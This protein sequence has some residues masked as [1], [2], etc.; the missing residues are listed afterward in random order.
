MKGATP[1]GPKVVLARSAD[2]NRKLSVRLRLLGMRP[3]PVDTVE[4]LEPSDWSEVDRALL[5]LARFDWVVLTSARGAEAFVDRARRLGIDHAKR[6]PRVAAVGEMTA[7]YLKKKGFEVG[8]VPSEYLT[9][10]LGEELPREFGDRVLL[11]RAE[12][13]SPEIIGIL[14]RRGFTVTS[15]P[16][17]HTRTVGTRVRGIQADGAD[18]VLFGSPSEVEGLVRRLPPAVLRRLR[19]K[20]VAACVGPVTAKAA[21]EAGFKHVLSPRVHTFDALLMEVRRSVVR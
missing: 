2:G 13:A 9:A 8:F 6:F 10:T 5:D 11:L 16:I 20:A 14:A 18:V 15:I 1:G 3:V 21:R 19:S 12:N 17:Y 7:E 4:F